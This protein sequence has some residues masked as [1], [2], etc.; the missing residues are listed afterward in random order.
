MGYSPWSHKEL[1][2]TEQL[3][4]LLQHSMGQLGSSPDLEMGLEHVQP[5]FVACGILVPQPGVEPGPLAVEAQSTNHW[6]AREVPVTSLQS[7]LLR[8]AAPR[9]L[10]EM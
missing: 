8:P 6:I 10:L 4:L 5:S 2:T 9:N 1:D 3:T 7:T